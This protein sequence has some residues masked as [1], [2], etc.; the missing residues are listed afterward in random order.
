[1]VATEVEDWMSTEPGEDR[2]NHPGTP[3]CRPGLQIIGADLANNARNKSVTVVFCS[4]PTEDPSVASRQSSPR[5]FG[6][7]SKAKFV[8]IAQATKD[9][10]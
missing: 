4:I 3:G 2:S 7:N 5:Q 10:A 9:E 1:M 6:T 8:A